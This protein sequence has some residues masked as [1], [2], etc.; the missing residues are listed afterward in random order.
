[1]LFL[2][3]IPI[4]LAAGLVLLIVSAILWKA[5]PTRGERHHHRH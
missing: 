1:M 2:S 3:R 5:S 4:P